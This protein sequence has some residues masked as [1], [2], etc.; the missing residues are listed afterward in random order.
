MEQVGESTLTVW[1][2][3]SPEEAVRRALKEGTTRPLLAVEDPV[4]TA[5]TLLQHRKAFYERAPLIVDSDQMGPEEL[6]RE[7]EG[8]VNQRG[9]V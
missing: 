5:R 8:Y 2:K 1:L 3:V 7:I 6:A 4:E 9:R